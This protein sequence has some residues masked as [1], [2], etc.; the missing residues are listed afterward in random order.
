MTVVHRLTGY[1][2]KTERLAIEHDIPASKLKHARE[3]ARIPH[4]D[5]EAVGSYQLD[6]SQ[7][8][9]IAMLVCKKIDVDHHAWFL[10]PFDESGS[11]ETAA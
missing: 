11:K 8:T 5:S 4:E 1:E 7:A 2:N 9:D 6:P 10:E 3:L